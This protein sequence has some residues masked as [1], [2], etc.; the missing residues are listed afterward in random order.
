M[1]ARPRVEERTHSEEL[2]IRQRYAH[3]LTTTT[4]TPQCAHQIQ[5]KRT[6]PPS[7][8][9]LARRPPT[10]DL[11]YKYFQTGEWSKTRLWFSALPAL[12]NPLEAA[13]NQQKENTVQEMAQEYTNPRQ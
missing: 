2:A 7:D 4:T 10:A 5:D 11:G 3:K 8:F 13:D 6:K 12:T 9:V 1:F